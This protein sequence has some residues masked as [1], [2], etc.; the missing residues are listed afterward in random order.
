MTDQTVTFYHWKECGHCVAFK[1]QW[2]V[3]AKDVL[4]TNNIKYYEYE[5]SENQDKIEEANI[6]AFPTIVIEK[7]TVKEILEGP[8][9]SELVSAVF[10]E[11]V[12]SQSGGGDFK[13]KIKHNMVKKIMSLK[14]ELK[15][16]RT[17]N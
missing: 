1:P 14:K 17:H 2:D 3:F 13:K 9:I 11:G 15:Y 4:K 8:T 12:P 7:G 10:P 6:K 16:V 5:Y